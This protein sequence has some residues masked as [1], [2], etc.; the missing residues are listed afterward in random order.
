MSIS[1][2]ESESESDEFVVSDH[3]SMPGDPLSPVTLFVPLDGSPR[4]FH[5]YDVLAYAHSRSLTVTSEHLH[6]HTHTHTHTLSDTH[7]QLNSFTLSCAP[8]VYQVTRQGFRQ[9]RLHRFWSR[10]TR[11][12]GGQCEPPSRQK[13]SDALIQEEKQERHR[14]QMVQHVVSKTGVEEPRLNNSDF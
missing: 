2:S 9:R 13:V 12:N 5:T 10:P 4:L 3:D 14:A 7:F 6:G 11:S 1:E 8:Y